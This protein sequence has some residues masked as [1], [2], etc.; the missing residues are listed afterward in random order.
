MTL[1]LV[2]RIVM[3]FCAGYTAY[4]LWGKG[5]KMQAILLICAAFL[6]SKV[7]EAVIS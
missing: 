1:T 2:F 6:L 5:Y 3:M 4:G 7:A